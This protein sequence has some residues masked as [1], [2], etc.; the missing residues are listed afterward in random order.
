MVSGSLHGWWW[1]IWG[2]IGSI[3]GT[4]L[5]GRIG[6]DPPLGPPPVMRPAAA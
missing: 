4:N 3:I 6:M 5:R 2:F 1:L